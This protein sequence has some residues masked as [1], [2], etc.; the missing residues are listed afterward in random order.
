MYQEL[1][2][3]ACERITNGIVSHHMDD[4]PIKIVLDPFNPTG[5]TRHVNFVS[6]KKTR[7]QTRMDRCH[8]NWVICDSDWE[9][10]FCRVVETHL[11]VRAYVKNHGLGLEV[12]Y[13]MGSEQ[14]RYIP[15]FIV[16]VDD[17]HGEDDLLNLV[18]EIKG[19]RGE[20][21][22]DKHST[23]DT[24]W[25]PGVNNLGS[26]GRWAFAEFTDVYDIQDDFE[27]ELDRRIQQLVAASN[28]A[29]SDVPAA[30]PGT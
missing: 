11:R 28:G 14:R 8:I 23:M 22:K 4:Y 16:L 29:V 19:F 2:D 15:D 26:H 9:A 25:I 17:G 6:S 13:R 27:A 5:S 24:Y 1:A 30:A 10:E 20:D 21:V 18:V 7:W 3:L 12:P